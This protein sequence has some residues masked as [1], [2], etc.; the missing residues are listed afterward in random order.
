MNQ[1]DIWTPCGLVGAFQVQFV[2]GGPFWTTKELSLFGS[3]RGQQVN[4]SLTALYALIAPPAQ[5]SLSLESPIQPLDGSSHVLMPPT[6]YHLRQTSW[7]RFPDSPPDRARSYAV[8]CRRQILRRWS[9][10]CWCSRPTPRSCERRSSI[11]AYLMR[12]MKA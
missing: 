4:R 11:G 7:I 1:K 10:N 2:T 9:D 3:S 12:S 6:S 8:E 5:E